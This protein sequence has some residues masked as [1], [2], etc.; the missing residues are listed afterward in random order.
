M[1]V[2]ALVAVRARK[3]YT[4]VVLV[5]A[6]GLGMVMLFAT[7]GAPDLALTQILV[8]TVTLVAFALVLRRI[9]ARLGEHNASVWPVARAVLGAAV[10]ATMAVVAVVA[11]SARSTKPISERF[12][13]LAYELGHGKN[14][15]NVA[16][17]DL[18]GWDTMGE[19]SVLILAATGVASLV[20]VTHRA[21]TLSRAIAP[22]PATAAGTRRPLVETA[23][24]I[25]P[26]GAGG[27]GWR[28]SSGASAS[29][30]RTARSC[31]R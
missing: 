27:A 24:G 22:L 31:S 18:R 6:T 2:A 9:P 28:G 4:G 26:R 20:F 5:S 3:R 19:L 25:K 14:V 13:E 10:G 8:E 30:L 1:I 7:S 29:T 21:D 23:D 15:V 16:L 17:V 12:P 11:T